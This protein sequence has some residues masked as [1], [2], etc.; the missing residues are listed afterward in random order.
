MNERDENRNYWDDQTKDTPI[1]QGFSLFERRMLALAEG[2]ETQSQMLVGPPGCG[3]GTV[4]A[5]ALKACGRQYRLIAGVTAKQLKVEFDECAS[6]G[7]VVV[8][9]D[10]D[11][12][13]KDLEC[14]EI[15][16]RA[17]SS[18]EDAFGRVDSNLTRKGQTNYSYKN[19]RMVIISNSDPTTP[20]FVSPAILE[21][22]IRPLTRRLRLSRIEATHE[23]RYRY[24]C[25]LIICEHIRRKSNVNP[26][27][28][29]RALEFFARHRHRMHDV[30]PGAVKNII[31]T[32]TVYPDVWEDDVA[33]G[34]DRDE[35]A[36]ELG[37]IPKLVAA[38]RPLKNR[39]LEPV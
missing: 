26:S 25:Y 14:L 7:I 3:K 38:D 30:S 32:M 35:P 17:T 28:V 8:V 22:K 19:L 36:P 2:S 34:F 16:M 12:N 18:E 29:N 33:Q 9:D 5:N 1:R 21:T 11:G 15:F 6:E 13:L 31:R 24:T 27:I 4:V 20:G 10:A 39:T 37:R 23:E